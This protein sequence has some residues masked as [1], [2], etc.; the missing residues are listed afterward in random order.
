[1]GITEAIIGGISRKRADKMERK[2]VTKNIL[3]SVK[4]I[5][6]RNH[7]KLIKSGGG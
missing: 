6:G 5:A 1:M 7:N 4:V 3:R 2:K